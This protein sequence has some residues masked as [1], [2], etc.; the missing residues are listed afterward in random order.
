MK[1]ITL[2]MVFA[3]ISIFAFSQTLKQK[4]KAK[5]CKYYK[6]DNSSIVHV[7]QKST[8]AALDTIWNDDFSDS[9]AVMTNYTF[10]DNTGNSYNWICTKDGPD[11]A[12]TQPSEIIHSTTVSNGYMLLN[13]DAYNTSGG[14][15]VSNPVN[16]DAYFQTPAI[17]CSGKS[18][19]VLKFE[20]KF[21]YC[22]SSATTHEVMVSNDGSTWTTFDV[23][24]GIFANT[25]T[26]DPD[27]VRINI[28]PIAANQ[29]TVYIRFYHQGASHY[30]YCIDDVLLYEATDHDLV[31]KKPFVDFLYSGTPV[32]Y[33]FPLSQVYG[34]NGIFFES[35]VH[36]LGGNSETTDYSVKVTRTNND[37]V[38]FNETSGLT[39]PITVGAFDTIQ[40][41]ITGS[42]MA[43]FPNETGTYRVRQEF[44]VPN[45]ATPDDNID[46][47]ITFDITDTVLA[48]YKVHDYDI[49]VGDYRTPA[50]DSQDGDCI[51]NMFLLSTADTISSINV[52]VKGGTD[53][54]AI[55]SELYATIWDYENGESVVLEAMLPKVIAGTDINQWV[56]LNFDKSDL[57]QLVLQPDHLYLYGFSSSNGNV[58][59]FADRS[60]YQAPGT[61]WIFITGDQWWWVT[62][63]ANMNLNLYRTKP[64]SVNSHNYIDFSVSQNYPNPV[65]DNTT[66]NYRL[67]QTNNVSLEVYDNLG[68]KVM[69]LYQGKKMA[70][71][72]SI[73]I[74]ASKL[75]A[76]IYTYKLIVNEKSVSKK[77]NVIK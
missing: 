49:C 57:S 11:G 38:V 22:C 74:D 31:L 9:T 58:K 43:F 28:T 67:T 41:D 53:G 56:T 13:G 62:S 19:V 51:A 23:Q 70:G 40:W 39:T 26:T 61:T 71:K 59:A 30:F 45:D 34:A 7:D 16:M 68:K 20:Q 73:N 47:S 33:Q 72:Y 69:T 65:K 35:K 4:Q 77:M 21:R 36:N 2:L 52:Y 1:K 75:S 15:M 42:D 60:T 55:G 48:V 29:S 76:G 6:G 50:G 12:Y 14:S 10:V 8:L 44:S 5:L 3:I 32:Y 54:T 27:V 64:L 37:S 18:T 24:E 46:S 66:I 63:V 25:A 17:D